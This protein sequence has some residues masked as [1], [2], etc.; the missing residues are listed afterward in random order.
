MVDKSELETTTD[1]TFVYNNDRLDSIERNKDIF[2]TLE[3]DLNKNKEAAMDK[4]E[5]LYKLRGGNSGVSADFLIDNMYKRICEYNEPKYGLPN[6]LAD[7]TLYDSDDRNKKTIHISDPTKL[8]T[9]N[10]ISMKEQ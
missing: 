8:D 5:E 4:L 2:G 10:D 1:A 7:L 9:I 6:T 3:P